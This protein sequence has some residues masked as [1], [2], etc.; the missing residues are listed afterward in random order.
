MGYGNGETFPRLCVL[1][2]NTFFKILLK[3]RNI[4]GL[5]SVSQDIENGLTVFFIFF[6]LLY[7][8]DCY[9]SNMNLKKTDVH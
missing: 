9:I 8:D 5:K 6:L 7:A 3:H 4:T 2:F 1:C